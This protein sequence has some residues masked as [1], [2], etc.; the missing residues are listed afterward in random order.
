MLHFSRIR[1]KRSVKA[2]LMILGLFALIGFV[3]KKQ[4][5]KVCATVNVRIQDT[6][7]TYFISENDVLSLMTNNGTDRL[8]G[9]PFKNIN[10][11][12]LELRIKSN[13]FI[14]S[15]QVYED[16]SGALNIEIEQIRPIARV[17][18]PDAPDWYISEEG[19]VL[20]VSERFTAR[21][22]LVDGAGADKLLNGNWL[23][24]EEGKA[25]FDLLN[26]IEKDKFWK[27]QIAQISIAPT[28]SITLYPQ[29]GKQVIEF[30]PALDYA[31]KFRN[32]RLFY[33]QILPVKGWN[34]YN[35]VSVAYEN[36]I[37][38]E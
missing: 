19:Y 22:V 3:E 27:A 12:K 23:E 38:C 18:H 29:V 34:R 9:T 21:V 28:G 25:F 33:K 20:P 10:I 4:R 26:F 5:T 1:L 2:T 8:I 17:I 13:K 36:Q 35:R 7:D 32:L 31:S 11:R 30:G 16:L 24:K 37:I 6:Y 14:R 15:C